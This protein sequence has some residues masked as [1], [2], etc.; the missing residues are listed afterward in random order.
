MYSS[1]THVVLLYHRCGA[2]SDIPFKSSTPEYL[3]LLNRQR[4]WR[5]G[6]EKVSGASTTNSRR[7]TPRK[8]QPT[9]RRCMCVSSHVLWTP[10]YHLSVQR[11]RAKQ[12]GSHGRRKEG[13]P[14]QEF[15]FFRLFKLEKYMHLLRVGVRVWVRDR[16]GVRVSNF[17]LRCPCPK[18]S[19][20]EEFDHHP[21]SFPP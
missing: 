5:S 6:G 10:V 3:F 15:I 4:R 16:V 14:T 8:G 1:F 9:T 18:I 7:R 19:S 21:P 13:Q 17:F 2:D 20:R 11:G 12:P